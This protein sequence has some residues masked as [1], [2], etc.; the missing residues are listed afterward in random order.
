[1]RLS[2]ISTANEECFLLENSEDDSDQLEKIATKL[3]NIICAELSNMETHIE[4]ETTSTEQ[5]LKA[6]TG[7]FKLVQ[8]LEEMIKRI[9][10]DRDKKSNRGVDILEFRKQLEKQIAKLVD[11]KTEKPIPG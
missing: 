8:N 10:T 5:K 4:V 3:K 1:M 9:Q 7:F 6:Y 11:E 2:F